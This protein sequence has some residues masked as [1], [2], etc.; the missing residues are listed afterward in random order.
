MI[1]PVFRVGDLVRIKKYK[2][3]K[4]QYGTE[5]GVVSVWGVWFPKDMKKFCEREFRIT[6]ITEDPSRPVP[7]VHGLTKRWSINTGMIEHVHPP[8]ISE[9]F[10]ASNAILQTDL[11]DSL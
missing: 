9:D 1:E 10:V 2:K 7:F 6:N 11:K 5:D 4:K 8:E 3:M